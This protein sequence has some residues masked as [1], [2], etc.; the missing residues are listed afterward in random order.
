GVRDC[1]PW[2]SASGP[3]FLLCSALACRLRPPVRCRGSLALV[4]RT[5]HLGKTVW[6]TLRREGHAATLLSGG[7]VVGV[8]GSDASGKSTLVREVSRWLG[9]FLSVAT[10]HGGKPPPTP[11]TLAPR[12]LLPLLRRLVPRYRLSRLEAD[13]EEGNAKLEMM[14]RGRLVILY[15][16][17]AVMLG[18]ERKRLL[19]RAHRKAA[20]GTLVIADRYPTRQPGV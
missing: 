10:V 8:V 16:L 5:R 2:A 7:A 6:R 14:P 9:E 12:A 13:A 11:V 3:R 4:L 19:V 15:A 20:G 1:M 17:R 18:Y